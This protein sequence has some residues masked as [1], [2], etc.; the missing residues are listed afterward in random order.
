MSQKSIHIDPLS[1]KSLDKAIRELQ[2]YRLWVFT[3]RRELQQKLSDELEK[4]LNE[5]FNS[6]WY[7]DLTEGGTRAPIF[8]VKISQGNLKSVAMVVGEEAVFVEFGAGVYHN[9]S[10]GSY[11]HPMA[12]EAGAAA[13]GTLGKGKGSRK[14]W[15][16]YD[17]KGQLRLTRGTAAQM[18]ALQAAMW[19]KDNV[20]R[21]AKTVFT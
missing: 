1:E 8:V 19:L 3:K 11:P 7:D 18:P 10:A 15:G 5:R 17:E 20:E 2:Q 6:A 13:I 21:I 12:E 16:F 9:G 14:V 4:Q